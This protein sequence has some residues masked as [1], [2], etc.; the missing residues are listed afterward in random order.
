MTIAPENPDIYYA[1]AFTQSLMEG[2]TQEGIQNYQK[3]A[4]FY[5][6]QG[7][8]SYS[9]NALEKIKEPKDLLDK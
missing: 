1:K 4:D 2:K 8:P 5:Q 9:K 7:K 6:Q 3:A